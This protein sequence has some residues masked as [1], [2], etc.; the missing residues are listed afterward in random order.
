[1]QLD[2][3]IDSRAVR[4]DLD[5]LEKRVRDARPFM[6]STAKKLYRKIREVFDTEGYGTWPALS[7]P[8]ASN[9]L[10]DVG[11]KT[12]LRYHDRY[13]KAATSP[14]TDDSIFHLHSDRLEIGVKA[15]NFP[16]M[17]PLKH[18]EGDPAKRLPRRPVFEYID[19]DAQELV[20]DMQRYL[21]ERIS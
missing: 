2:I 1:M 4:H 18:E 6:R 17:Y 14:S 5:L 7:E 12:I 9:K 3:K 8:Y 19:V 20:V 21:F 11:Y 16:D 15:G 13:Y 10:A